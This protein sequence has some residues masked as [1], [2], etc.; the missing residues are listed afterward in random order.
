MT[1]GSARVLDLFGARV[2]PAGRPRRKQSEIFSLES[3]L[4]DGE[5]WLVAEQIEKRVLSARSNPAAEWSDRSGERL[6][7]EAERY[8]KCGL[9]VLPLDCCDCASGYMVPIFCRSR[10]CERCGRIYRNQIAKQIETVL[11]EC[12]EADR[13]GYVLALLTLTVNSRRW[14]GRMPSRRDIKRF[15]G[16]KSQFLRLYFGK[17]RGVWTKKGKIREDRKRF[18]GAGS[19]GVL[20]VGHDNNNLHFHAIVYGPIKVWADMVADWQRITGDS[21][22]VDIRARGARDPK[23]LASYV[24]K[25][26]TKPPSG[27][28]GFIADYSIMIKGS[29]RLST[30]GIFYRRIKRTVKEKRRCSCAVC[31]GRLVP[32]EP[33]L[34]H[35]S[36]DRLNLYQALDRAGTGVPDRNPDFGTKPEKSQRVT[37][38]L[39]LPF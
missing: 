17:F 10:I 23:R 26:M 5:R 27:H 11:N 15:M 35:R 39:I 12:I 29:R 32:L 3:D 37:L 28:Y 33:C 19:V 14:G 8:A 30:S 21:R 25:Y 38:P 20:E 36:G 6:L 2:N 16:E 7:V 1:T 34:A 31:G 9:E 18:I 13:R 24:L 4:S 22:G